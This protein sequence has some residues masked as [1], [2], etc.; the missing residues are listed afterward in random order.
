MVGWGSRD[1]AAR[2][3]RDGTSLLIGFAGGLIAAL[4]CADLASS[5]RAPQPTGPSRCAFDRGAG[6]GR[7]AACA[8]TLANRSDAGGGGFALLT[9]GF[10][11]PAVQAGAF[12]GA[13]AALLA[14]FLFSLRLAERT[15]SPRDRRT[16]SL[17]VSRLGF[18]GAAFRPARSVLSA[19]LVASAAFIIV[20]VDAFRR[21][22]G[23]HHESAVG[24]RRFRAAGTV[25]SA[26]RPQS[27]YQS[28]TGGA[29]DAGA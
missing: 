5:G 3:A 6:R 23:D 28:G 11:S 4:A 7:S 24:H 15:R 12:F 25:G 14:A 8:A 19:A 20:S 10:V 13:S 26:D 18:R 22:G 17:T 21:G 1:D 29:P 2:A 9:L 16:G 27:R